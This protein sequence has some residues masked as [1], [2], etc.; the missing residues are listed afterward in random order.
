MIWGDYHIHTIYSGQNGHATCVPKGILRQAEKKGL[1]Q[2]GICDHGVNHVFYATNSNRLK[3]L[4]EEIDELNSSQSSVKM[5]MGI[6]ANIYSL[7]GDIDVNRVEKIP[8]DLVVAGFH[9]MVWCKTVKDG[10]ELGFPQ[11]FNLQSKEVERKFTNAVISAIKRN[12]I[13]I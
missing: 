6:E 1:K 11:I 12:K 4:R 10:A 13:D 2:V 3:K 8:F 9:K 5:L 7:D